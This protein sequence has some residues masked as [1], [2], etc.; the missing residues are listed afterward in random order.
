M[1]FDYFRPK[2]RREAL[3]LLARQDYQAL[4]LI[5]H[6]KPNDPRRMGADAFVDLSLLGMDYIKT[7]PDGAVHIGALATL[8]EMVDSPVLHTGALP[9]LSKAAELV[10]GPGIRNLSGLWGVIQALGGPP[11][12][13][14]ALL[15]LDAQ[16]V[17][18]ELSETQRKVSI[19]EFIGKGADAIHRGEI[20]LEACLPHLGEDCGWALERVARTPRDEAI[21]ASVAIV[22]VEN[23]KAALVRLALAGANSLPQR[24]PEVERKLTGQAFGINTLQAACEAVVEQA[25]PVEDFRGSAEYRRAMAGVVT[26]R[27]LAQAWERATNQTPSRERKQP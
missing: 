4:P 15:A 3:E 23:S 13:V 25:V 24:L 12:V 17:L 21:V 20:V 7:A 26:R 27:A 10:A 5:V 6:P 16:I 1:P 22:E 19:E 11:E 2:T 14:L 18:L 8:Q 9:L